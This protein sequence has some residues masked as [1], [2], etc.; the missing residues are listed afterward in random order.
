MHVSEHGEIN[1]INVSNHSRFGGLNVKQVV[2]D[3][4]ILIEH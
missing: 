3:K 1:P 4:P 2:I